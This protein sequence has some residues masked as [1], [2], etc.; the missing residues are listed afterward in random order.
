MAGQLIRLSLPP[1]KLLLVFK[2][3]MVCGMLRESLFLGAASDTSSAA[4]RERSLLDLLLPATFPRS[5]KQSAP[6]QNKNKIASSIMLPFLL[7]T[8]IVHVCVPFRTER[9]TWGLRRSLYQC[10]CI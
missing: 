7:K 8:S 9:H 5:L 4:L 1:D 2:L 3:L 10:A 6:L